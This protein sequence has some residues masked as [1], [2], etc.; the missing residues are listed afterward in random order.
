MATSL[1]ILFSFPIFI[2]YSN[3]FNIIYSLFE[4]LQYYLFIIRITSILFI[5]YSNYFNIIYSIFELLQY[6]LF[7]IRITS[8]L[9]TFSPLFELLQHYILLE[10][11]EFPVP[12]DLKTLPRSRSLKAI[13]G[14]SPKLMKKKL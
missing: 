3:Y 14:S 4:L 13:A 6:Y 9:Y 12:Y 5:H 10:T 8:I 7:I 2:H 11:L 1:S